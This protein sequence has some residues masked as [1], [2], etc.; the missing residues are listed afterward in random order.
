MRAFLS[1]PL[2]DA[3]CAYLTT[4]IPLLPHATFTVPSQFDLTMKFLGNVSEATLFELRERLLFTS[5]RPFEARLSH[6]GVFSERMIRVVWIGV[7][8]IERFSE[9]HA[10]IEARLAPLF[11]HDDR[12]LPHITL[13]RV[14]AVQDKRAFRAHLSQIPLKPMS[15]LVDRLSLIKSELTSTGAVHT[16]ILDIPAVA[17][18]QRGAS[19]SSGD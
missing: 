15:F 5:F 8:P 9:L 10:L 7:E 17:R 11:P 4:R 14:T 3:L 1:C 2:S 16:P 19:M 13:A 12:F 6:L 18:H